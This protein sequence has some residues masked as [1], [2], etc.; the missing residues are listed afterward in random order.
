[1]AIQLNPNLS[2]AYARRGSIYYKMGD[3]DRATINWNLALRIDPGYDDVR[4]ILKIVSENRLRTTS[5][6]GNK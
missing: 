2:L 3:L 5:F 4:N 1:M 6:I